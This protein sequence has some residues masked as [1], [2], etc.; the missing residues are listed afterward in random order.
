MSGEVIE[1]A[2]PYSRLADLKKR[3][4]L[5]RFNHAV[6]KMDPNE[7]ILKKKSIFS[8]AWFKSK[9]QEAY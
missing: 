9:F 8:T 4:L 7:N 6:K 5:R 3:G 2:I 1:M